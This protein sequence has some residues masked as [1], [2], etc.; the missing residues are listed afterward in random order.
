MVC[1]YLIEDA[2]Y[3]PLFE[4]QK[5]TVPRN[6]PITTP[7]DQHT[8]SQQRAL[9]VATHIRNAIVRLNG[10]ENIIVIGLSDDQKSYLELPDGLN[11]IS[12]NHQE[13]I[14]FLLSPFFEQ[15]PILN[16]RPEDVLNG[17]YEAVKSKR[18]LNI[19]SNAEKFEQST[20]KATSC[21][22]IENDG[23]SGP[24]VAVNYALSINADIIIVSPITGEEIKDIKDQLAKWKTNNIIARQ[25]LDNYI[26]SRIGG[27]NFSLYNYTTFFTAGIPYSLLLG[28]HTVCTYVHLE[29][30]PD[31]FTFTNILFADAPG[32][33]TALLFSPIDFN[34]P[35]PAVEL[36]INQVTTLMHEMNY[37]VKQLCGKEASIYNLSQY[38]EFY[39]FDVLHFS[40]HGGEIPGIRIKSEFIDK[41][42]KQHSLVYDHVRSIVVTPWY[43]ENGPIIEIKH[44]VFPLSYNG[45]DVGSP[46][47]ADQQYSAEFFIE[48]QNV[49]AENR[50]IKDTLIEEIKAVPNSRSIMCSDG[51]FYG[52]FRHLA[53]DM[54]PF[55][56]NNTCWSWG[57]IVESFIK[58]GARGY[59][60]TLWEVNDNAA[61]NT[62]IS[63]YKNVKTMPTADALQDAANMC[64]LDDDKNIYIIFGFPFTK[65]HQSTSKH[66]SKR[67][68]R[69][70]LERD[71]EYWIRTKQSATNANLRNEIDKIISWHTTSIS[72][73]DNSVL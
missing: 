3:L 62:A 64:Q 10:C 33:G 30:S 72:S 25:N 19:D 42:G 70:K 47:L 57:E 63:F 5:V 55:I 16:C 54:K 20:S 60:G 4:I 22:V 51:S 73:L 13:D 15:K 69:W 49:I 53:G 58:K 7:Q 36:E 45:Y 43:N 24:I 2:Y 50:T 44:M 59:I 6:F 8:F 12:I 52:I 26:T 68:L 65:L 71:K 17:L 32:T 28:K 29:F 61:A 56:F 66:D 18:W 31:L 46:E 39:P 67:K 1:S 41:T 35:L 40:S 14:D 9:E 48:C 38:L 11:I 37:Q 34:P 27:V 21:V 23:T